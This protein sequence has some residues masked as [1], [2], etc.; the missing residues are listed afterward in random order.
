[1]AT[2]KDLRSFS[3]RYFLFIGFPLGLIASVLLHFGAFESA[4]IVIVSG[5]SWYFGAMASLRLFGLIF[6]P[7]E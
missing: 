5:I 1:M 3:P 6:K 7:P 2:R 4:V